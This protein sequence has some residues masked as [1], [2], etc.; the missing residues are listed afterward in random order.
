M[1]QCI[2]NQNEIIANVPKTLITE[3]DEKFRLR[4]NKLADFYRSNFQEEPAFFV[5]VP[6]R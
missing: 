5:R 6:G 1:H 3:K 2:N 4:L